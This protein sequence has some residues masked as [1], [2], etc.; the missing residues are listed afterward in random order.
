MSL[1]RLNFDEI[2]EA[3]LQAL[4][5][6][7]VPEGVALDYKRGPY[8]RG[9][10]DVKEFLKDVSSFANSVG[11]HLVI[12]MD[13]VGGVA[14]AITPIIGLD[15]DHEVQRLESL[16]RDGIKPRISGIRSKAVP[17]AGG[18]FAIVIR[19]PKSWNP[20]HRV[21][22]RNT[23][24]FYTRNS[25]GVHEVSVEELRVLFS[26]SATVQDRIR[27]FRRERLA[28]VTG[29]E[30]PVALATNRGKLLL[31]IVPLLAFSPGRKLTCSALNS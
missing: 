25:A 16:M 11:G 23:S 21:S 6:T 14:T 18:G 31:H 20:P 7:G 2:W 30:T 4:V 9:D 5:E 28:K 10:V 22:A 3:E 19:I 8:G 26:V 24:R 13:E 15:A 29:G 12:G 17:V 1:G 27:A